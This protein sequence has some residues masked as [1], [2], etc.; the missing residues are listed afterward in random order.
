MS[1]VIKRFSKKQM[2]VLNWWHKKSPHYKRD[3][4]ICDGAVRSGKTFC[5]SLSFFIWS[6]YE[7]SGADYALCGKTI[8]SLRRNMIT[9]IIPLLESIGF[10][11][12]EKLSRNILIVSYG[13][14]ARLL[15]RRS[16]GAR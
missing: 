14:S 4:I 9:P 10:A 2:T 15:S 7:N 1:A 13:G 16:Q 12:E 8:S 3:A 11:C 5:M 6:F